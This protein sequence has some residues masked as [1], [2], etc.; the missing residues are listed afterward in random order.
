MKLVGWSIRNGVAAAFVMLGFVV[1]VS[2]PWLPTFFDPDEGFQ[3]AKAVPLAEGRAL[4][5]DV[6]C[7]QVPLHT[8]SLTAWLELVGFSLV[9]GRLT[10]MLLAAA[11]TASLWRLIRHGMSGVDDGRKIAAAVVALT[12]LAISNHWIDHAQV[13]MIGLPAQFMVVISLDLVVTAKRC[14]RL[15]QDLSLSLLAGL[16]L[17]I[18]CM[19]KLLVVPAVA[20]ISVVAVLGHPTPRAIVRGSLVLSVSMLIA[21]AIA[22]HTGV[23]A[24]WSQAVGVATQASNDAMGWGPDRYFQKF[25]T[26]RVA[27]IVFAVAGVVIGR[28]RQWKGIWPALILLGFMELAL[29]W[30]R[31]FRYHSGVLITIVLSWLSGYGVVGLWDLLRQRIIDKQPAELLGKATRD[32]RRAGI[33]AICIGSAAALLLS[34]LLHES[35]EIDP[36][37][38]RLMAAG[39]EPVISDLAIYPFVANRQVP[40]WLAV[41]S[42][43]R[44]DVEANF[45]QELV[46]HA[47]A[48]GVRQVML[49][50]MKPDRIGPIFDTWLGNCFV[51]DYEHDGNVL[52]RRTD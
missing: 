37:L 4:Y 20:A 21:V 34:G 52:Y 36:Q 43:K 2:P 45:D 31:P 32:M 44:I 1:A 9:N 5:V 28:R 48:A 3:F 25:H 38:V 35:E 12:F 29:Y 6:W 18:A 27:W 40:P 47:E 46:D 15:W 50:R 23:F 13:V 16:L 26:R 42:K 11:A 14:T 17:G 7:D 41:I 22:W 30:H 8:I 51:I 10:T 24:H 33:A 39:G 19:L 49:G